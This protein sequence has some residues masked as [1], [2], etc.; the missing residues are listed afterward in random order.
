MGYNTRIFV[1][2]YQP[3]TIYIR[4]GHEQRTH[5]AEH[6]EMVH[7]Q[8]QKWTGTNYSRQVYVKIDVNRL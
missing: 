5:R 8:S 2:D 4:F 1:Y 6:F 3:D 7:D